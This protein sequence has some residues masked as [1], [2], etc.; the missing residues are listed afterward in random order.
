MPVMKTTLG[1]SG[2]SVDLLASSRS[3]RIVST[4]CG[5]QLHL[6]PR[7][8]EAR[9]ADDAPPHAGLVARRAPA[10]R[11]S[12]GPILPPTPSSI[13]SPSS[14]A[15]AWMAGVARLAEQVFELFEDFHA[16]WSRGHA[17]YEKQ[18]AAEE[19]ILTPDPSWPKVRAQ[20]SSICAPPHI[21][22][23]VRCGTSPMDSA[24]RY[25]GIVGAR[26]V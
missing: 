8:R 19:P 15:I 11:A 3:Q 10:M 12:V 5:L 20:S 13:R 16:T 1:T 17:S 18:R 9:H 25:G 2:S 21:R 26:Y 23:S 6:Q 24:K 22:V 4:P 14:R 7:R